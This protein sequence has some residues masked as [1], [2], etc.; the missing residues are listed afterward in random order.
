MQH[1]QIYFIY[2]VFFYII[3][4]HKYLIACTLIH[5]KQN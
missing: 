3:I 5:K 4:E 1:V 2:F